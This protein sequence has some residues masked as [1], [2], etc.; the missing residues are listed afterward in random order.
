MKGKD[1]VRTS[2]D[3]DHRVDAR[4]HQNLFS[5]GRLAAVGGDCEHASNNGQMDA[6]GSK[7]GFA[8]KGKSCGRA[9]SWVR[10]L[11]MSRD[12][13]GCWARC[14]LREQGE[15]VRMGDAGRQLAEAGFYGPAG[16][17]GI[18][19]REE[20]R[21]DGTQF[22]TRPGRALWVWRH[23]QGKIYENWS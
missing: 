12:D 18:G 16:K 8:V 10:M 3:G 14:G 15:R 23:S 7:L 17:K 4:R 19:K 5:V 11:A 22:V 2:V 13:R 1:G 20:T 21:V 6:T 9:K